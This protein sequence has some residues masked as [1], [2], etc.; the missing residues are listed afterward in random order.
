VVYIYNVILYI[1]HFDHDDVLRSDCVTRD[2]FM[3]NVNCNWS[4]QM[5]VRENTQYA[6]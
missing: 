4:T 6:R 3:M 2:I 5:I 1:K